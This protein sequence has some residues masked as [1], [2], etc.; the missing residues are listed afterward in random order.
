MN[1]LAPG[2]SAA[3]KKRLSILG[4]EGLRDVI[5]QELKE[6]IP[7]KSKCKSSPIGFMPE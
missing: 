4:V 1:S 5:I 6:E 3:A 2:D 7:V